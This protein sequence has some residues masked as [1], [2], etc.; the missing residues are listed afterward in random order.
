[1]TYKGM[2]LSALL[3]PC[4]IIGDNSVDI[5]IQQLE[6]EYFQKE[7]ELSRL[8]DMIAERDKLLSSLDSESQNLFESLKYKKIKQLEKKNDGK[9][10]SEIEQNQLSDALQ[11]AVNEFI[12]IFVATCREKKDIKGIL[13]EGLFVRDENA[14]I[15]EFESLRFHLIRAGVERDLII[16]LVKQYEDCIRKLLAIETELENLK[17]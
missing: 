11:D 10:L 4:A 17:N 12:N 6:D 7:L 5:R 3:A 2:L 13:S 9:P 14:V 16:L 1:M 8:G 15:P